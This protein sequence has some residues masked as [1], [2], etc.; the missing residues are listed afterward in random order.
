LFDKLEKLSK[1]NVDVQ[2]LTN[3]S[4]KSCFFIEKL[5]LKKAKYSISS[6]EGMPTFILT[7]DEQLLLLIRKNN[8]RKKVAA[9][10]TNYDAFAKAMKTLFLGLWNNNS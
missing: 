4:P 2:L 3:Y 6:V 7:D 1:K 5:K 9:L 10:W 8:G